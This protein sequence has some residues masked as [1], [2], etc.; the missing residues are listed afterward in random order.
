MR[1][2]TADVPGPSKTIR[3]DLDV[4]KALKANA[5][6]FDDTPNTVLRRLLAESGYMQPRGKKIGGSK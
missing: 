6:P 5:T 3:I 1:R 4:Y 2:R